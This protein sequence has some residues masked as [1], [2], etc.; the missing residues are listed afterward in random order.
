MF[1]SRGPL[2]LVKIPPI[3]EPTPDFP[4]GARDWLSENKTFSGTAYRGPR[5]AWPRDKD[6]NNDVSFSQKYICSMVK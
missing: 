4:Y 5:S 6:N 2:R 1:L 3:Q